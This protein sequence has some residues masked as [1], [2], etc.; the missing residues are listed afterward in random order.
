MS[1]DLYRQLQQKLDAYS[2][3]FP[4]TTTG[5]EIEILKKLFREDDARVFLAL[6]PRLESASALAPRLG[7]SEAE[8]AAKLED[9]TD[10]GL[11]FRLGPAE[12]RRYGTIAFVHGLFEF[13]VKRLDRELADLMA[14][15]FADGFVANMI[16]NAGGFLRT[17]PVERAVEIENRIAAYEDAC[18]LLRGKELIVVADCICRKAKAMM[19]D[20]CGKPMEVC[21]MFGSMGQYYLDHQMGRRV[22]ADEAIAILQKAQEAGLVTQPASAKNP[23]GMCNCCG[24]CCGVLQSIRQH[25]RPAEVVF[26]NHFAEVDADLCTGCGDCEDICQMDAIAVGESDTAEVDR[27]RCIGCGLCVVACSEGAAKLAAKPESQ[28]RTPPDNSLQ[29]MIAMAKKRG[30]L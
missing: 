1:E 2:V 14:R 15:Y 22:D 9:M 12:A 18:A 6:S 5:V 17:V 10:R 4:A 24:D 26:S 29:Q 28:R 3:G 13:Q 11:L 20:G 21:Y 30:V 8:A 27:D 25:P 16:A 23:A 7:L 19:A